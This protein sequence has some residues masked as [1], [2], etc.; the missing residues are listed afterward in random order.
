[1]VTDSIK[2]DKTITVEDFI[3]LRTSDELTY[4]NYSLL[5]Y[6]NGH[7]MFIT[8]LLYDYDDEFNDIAVTIKLSELEQ[9]KY[10]YKPYLFAYDIYGS[11]EL[12]F[13]VMMMNSIIDPKEFDFERVKVIKPT[14]LKYM[15]ARIDAVNDEYMSLNRSRLKAQYK[16]N[17]GNTIWTE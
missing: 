2:A 13:I 4:Y 8:S 16:A 10:K 14:D 5:E 11:T 15:L 3:A 17:E 1:M 6:I 7:N 9:A 12:K